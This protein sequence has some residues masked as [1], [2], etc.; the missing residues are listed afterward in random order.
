MSVR[1][2]ADTVEGSHGG[3][4]RAQ[5]VTNVTSVTSFKKSFSGV[6]F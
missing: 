5:L 1:E 2:A 3:R 6:L 4:R